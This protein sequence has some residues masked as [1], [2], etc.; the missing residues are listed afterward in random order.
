MTSDNKIL[1]GNKLS[2]KQQIAALS[3]NNHNK[4]NNSINNKSSIP[5]LNLTNISTEQPVKE[6]TG[7]YS[8]N[9]VPK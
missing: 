8:N 2:V 3:N 9:I 6:N 1:S 4:V 7:N 5:Q